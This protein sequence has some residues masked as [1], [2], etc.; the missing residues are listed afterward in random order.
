MLTDLHNKSQEDTE[1]NSICKQSV[2]RSNSE[3][4]SKQSSNYRP[5][6]TPPNSGELEQM[7]ANGNTS[8]SVSNKL[9]MMDNLLSLMPSTSSNSISSVGSQ[10]SV[11]DGAAKRAGKT[12]QQ[13]L[14]ER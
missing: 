6:S 8:L 4:N 11:V 2:T 1:E 9:L 12:R 7:N 3:P 13:V 14:E 5:K 10:D